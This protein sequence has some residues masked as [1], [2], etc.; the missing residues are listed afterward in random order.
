M[1]PLTRGIAASVARASLIVLLGIAFLGLSATADR[2]YAATLLVD[3]S[4][5]LTGAADV[6]VGGV[7]FDVHFRD[8]TCA[9]PFSGCNENA[10]FAS[11]DTIT[12]SNALRVQVFSETVSFQFDANPEL[13]LGCDDTDSCGVITP[14]FISG[15]DTFHAH[16]FNNGANAD[17]IFGHFGT[18]NFDLA[19]QPN[20]VYAIWLPAGSIAPTL[21]PLPPAFLLFGSAFAVLWWIRRGRR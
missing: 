20:Q 17:A 1:D 7:L 6:D 16:R 10:D 8:G 5:S 4:G 3:G 14:N 13:T 11:L 2:S 15:E 12:A 21:V 18:A 19:A 9:A